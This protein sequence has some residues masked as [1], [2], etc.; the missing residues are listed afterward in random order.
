MASVF[1]WSDIHMSVQ[2]ISFISS[3]HSLWGEAVML[4]QLQCLLAVFAPPCH[5]HAVGNHA[6]VVVTVQEP[7]YLV[8]LTHMLSD[9]LV[10][11]SCLYVYKL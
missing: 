11:D 2:V 6:M 3:N 7:P 5:W 10:N 1:A 9:S 4:L 8:I